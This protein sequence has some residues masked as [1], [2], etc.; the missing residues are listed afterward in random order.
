MQGVQKEDCAAPLEYVPT[1]H[2]PF[3]EVKARL[4]QK[5]PGGQGMQADCPRLF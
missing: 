3:G 1:A 4:E 2:I 5:W